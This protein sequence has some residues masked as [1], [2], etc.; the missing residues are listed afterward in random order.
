LA[1]GPPAVGE[2]HERTQPLGYEHL[3]LLA[4]RFL[5]RTTLPCGETSCANGT[6]IATA[7]TNEM[8]DTASRMNILIVDDQQSV[9]KTTSYALRTMGHTPFTAENSRQTWR[10]LDEEPIDAMF[11]DIMLGREQGLD[12]L[13]EIKAKDPEVSVIVFTAQASIE[14]AVEAMR[15]GAYDYIQR[16]RRAAGV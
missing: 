16:A 3:I 11:L 13:S 8:H 10:V 6:G 14:S 9:L 4:D 1:G 2:I 12:L 7:G 15:R 5:R